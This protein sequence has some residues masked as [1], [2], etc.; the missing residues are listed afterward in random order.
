M[1]V[2]NTVYKLLP[3]VIFGRYSIDKGGLKFSVGIL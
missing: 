1:A 2:E 3:K